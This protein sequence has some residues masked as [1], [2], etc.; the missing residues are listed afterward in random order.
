MAVKA[1][2]SVGVSGNLTPV[3]IQNDWSLVIAASLWIR[4]IFNIVSY[5]KNKLIRD[6]FFVG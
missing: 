5:G 3:R 1:G 2:S 4:Q 6:E